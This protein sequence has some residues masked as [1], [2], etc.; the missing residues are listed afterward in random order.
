METG[1]GSLS[2]INKNEEAPTNYGVARPV[3][4]ALQNASSDNSIAESGEKVN[5]N[6]KI[7]ARE[8]LRFFVLRAYYVVRL[9]RLLQ[10]AP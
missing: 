5:N 7:K 8:I 4:Y 1:D 2:P 6:A 3:G 10:A 9:P